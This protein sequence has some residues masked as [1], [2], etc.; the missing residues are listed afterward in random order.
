MK[1]FVRTLRQNLPK[2]GPSALGRTLLSVFPSRSRNLFDTSGVRI[3]QGC[4]NR[5]CRCIEP[6][7]L[8]VEP[9]LLH[10]EA[11]SRGSACPTRHAPIAIA[12]VSIGRPRSVAL[13]ATK[14]ISARACAHIAPQFL[15]SRGDWASQR[16]HM[17]LPAQAHA[18]ARV[19]LLCH[20][21]GSA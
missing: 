19:L 21:P 9:Q 11:I 16:I 4:M 13:A 10:G 2:V 12:K 17:P 1:V 20:A 14:R 8:P 18:H 6:C 15:L 7:L 5:Y 3:A